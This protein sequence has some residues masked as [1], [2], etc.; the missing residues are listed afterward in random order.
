MNISD[1]AFEVYLTLRIKMNLYR[2]CE[3]LVTPEG[4][5]IMIRGLIEF[6]AKTQSWQW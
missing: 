5:V 1:D 2:S 4:K 6:I 3:K